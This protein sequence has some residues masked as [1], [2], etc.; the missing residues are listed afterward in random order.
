MRTEQVANKF[1]KLVDEYYEVREGYLDLLD[2]LEGQEEYILSIRKN[3]N[4]DLYTYLRVLK[5]ADNRLCELTS[6]SA[7][8]S[9]LNHQISDMIGY[10]KYYIKESKKIAKA[11]LRKKEDIVL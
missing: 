7:R 1:D 4:Q 9:Y 2:M 3:N 5:G 6:S 10:F 8:S 11:T